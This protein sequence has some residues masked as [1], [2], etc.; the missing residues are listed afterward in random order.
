MIDLMGCAELMPSK[1]VQW[2]FKYLTYSGG[3]LPGKKSYARHLKGKHGK[4]YISLERLINVLLG[5][6]INNNCHFLNSA[7]ENRKQPRNDHV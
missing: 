3:F 4:L 1:L 5:K 6:K 7:K 2:L